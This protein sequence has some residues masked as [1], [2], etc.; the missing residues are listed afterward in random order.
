MARWCSG[1]TLLSQG[2]IV[3]SNPARV[4]I[5]GAAAY[6]KHAQQDDDPT[7]S[8]QVRTTMAGSCKSSNE[9]QHL[10]QNTAP[11]MP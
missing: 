7:V 6:V 2:G 9:G 1:N 4:T 10:A 11:R 3:G 8:R 5:N